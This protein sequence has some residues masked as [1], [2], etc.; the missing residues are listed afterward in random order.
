MKLKAL[1][2][3]PAGDE[4]IEHQLAETEMVLEAA[5]RGKRMHRPLAGGGGSAKPTAKESSDSTPVE[6][7]ESAVPVDKTEDLAASEGSEVLDEKRE[8]PEVEDDEEDD[9]KAPAARKRARKG[10]KG[11]ADIAAGKVQTPRAAREDTTEPVALPISDA[12]ARVMQSAPEG[13]IATSEDMADLVKGLTQPVVTA[14]SADAAA[15]GQAA[16]RAVGPAAVPAVSQTVGELIGQAAAGVIAAPLL[17]LTSAH[18]HLKQRFRSA[19]EPTV[20]NDLPS[21]RGEGLRAPVATLEKISNWKCEQIEKAAEGVLAA[22]TDLRS[23]DGFVLWEEGVAKEASKRGCSVGEI[24]TS[25]RNDADLAPLRE[26]M[27]ALWKERPDEFE[28][29]RRE[30]DTFE[31]RIKDVREKFANSDESIRERVVGSMKAV[32]SG[33]A[34]LPG[35]GKDEGEYMQTLAERVRAMAEVFKEII[36][37]LLSKLLGRENADSS[38]ENVSG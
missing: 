16:P 5:N 30:S 38:P 32:E 37:A 2:S 31:K 7:G 10:L 3:A 34:D 17:G 27:T 8:P 29:Y 14:A 23:L 15:S 26:V 20:R 21:T 1:S 35:L 12:A 33:T 25:M 28:A 18:R 4:F 36:S 9:A 13:S 11:L 22:A 6:T 19:P 24:V